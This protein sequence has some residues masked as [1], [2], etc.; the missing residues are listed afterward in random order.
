MTE[1]ELAAEIVYQHL[2][3]GASAMSFDPIVASGPNSALPHA[4]PT[5]RTLQQGDMVVIDMGCFVN[6]Y[7]SD[8][9][10]TIS[11]GEPDEEARKVY[12]V[13]LQAQESALSAASA[14]LSNSALDNVARSFIKDSGYG[15]YFTHSLGHGVGLQIHEWPSISW[16]M[17]HP[18]SAGMV[19]TIEPGIYLPG[20]VGVR[21][22][23]MIQLTQDGCENLTG[24]TKELIVI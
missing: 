1:Q 24:S 20:K 4:R 7:A 17:D 21:I 3:R 22:E 11:I 15:A 6:G 14:Q 12:N 2:R 5:E 10:R 9:T 19:L 18:L 23:D 13:V 16:R 8:M